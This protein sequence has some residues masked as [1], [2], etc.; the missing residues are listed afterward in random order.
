VGVCVR[1]QAEADS[2]NGNCDDG[3]ADNSNGDGV[4]DGDHS[5]K[6]T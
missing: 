2:D 5:T 1:I 6:S 3:N 4:D